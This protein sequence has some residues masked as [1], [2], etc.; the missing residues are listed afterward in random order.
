MFKDGIIKCCDDLTKLFKVFREISRWPFANTGPI[1]V[2]E[3]LRAARF[4]LLDFGSHQLYGDII[5]M[6]RQCCKTDKTTS[7]VGSGGKKKTANDFLRLQPA[8]RW[9]VAPDINLAKWSYCLLLKEKNWRHKKKGFLFFASSSV[10][11]QL[12]VKNSF[13]GSCF[14][15]LT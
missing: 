11:Q 2:N 12:Q 8:H 10:S 9:K 5:Q 4:F 3:K 15:Y 6:H 14:K 7:L 1:Y 13:L